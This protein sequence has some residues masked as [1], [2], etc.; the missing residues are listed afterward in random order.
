MADPITGKDVA[1]E[2]LIA[3][4]RKL[5]K[6]LTLIPA[7]FASLEP[8]ELY[9]RFLLIRPDVKGNAAIA[10]GSYG[11]SAS[12][13]F[14]F[15]FGIFL[16]PGLVNL[17]VNAT[18]TATKTNEAL[19]IIH[20]NLPDKLIAT[21][22]R[23]SRNKRVLAKISKPV[24]FMAMLGERKG[25]SFELAFAASFG[26]GSFSE[27]FSLGL[28]GF[29]FAGG[30]ISGSISRDVYNFKDP[31]PGWYQSGSDQN[32][33][34]DF[35]DSLGTRHTHYL[36]R[37]IALWLRYVKK[38]Y[39]KKLPND[40]KW[41]KLKQTFNNL[42][43]F[44]PI[45]FKASTAEVQFKL[46]NILKELDK[47][48]EGFR[49]AKFDKKIAD[50]QAE[51]TKA[52]AANK[53]YNIGDTKKRGTRTTLGDLPDLCKIHLTNMKGQTSIDVSVGNSPVTG[54]MGGGSGV[55]TNVASGNDKLD[56]ASTFT[57]PGP[58]LGAGISLTGSYTRTH[59]RYQ[60]YGYSSRSEKPIVHTQD[61]QIRYTKVNL[62]VGLQASLDFLVGRDIDLEGVRFFGKDADKLS[63]N[64]LSYDKSF[65]NKMSYRAVTAYWNHPTGTPSSVKTLNGSGVSFGF[66]IRIQ[67]LLRFSRD[68]HAGTA[69]TFYDKEIASY[70]NLL[71][72]TSSEFRQFVKGLLSEEDL[73]NDGAYE[74]LKAYGAVLVESS[75][76]FQE[77][78]E[79]SFKNSP[80]DLADLTKSGT[81]WS[82][83]YNNKSFSA[84]TA[85]L[86][87]ES[88]RMRL[89]LSDHMDNSKNIFRL[90]LYLFGSGAGVS[91]DKVEQAGNEG[92]LDFYTHWFLQQDQNI[93]RLHQNYRDSVPPVILLPHT[94]A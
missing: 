82:D 28:L 91:V 36:K 32:L 68:E 26:T 29:T 47:L 10:Y 30:Q 9:E 81:K 41:D 43:K 5:K 61:T 93:G 65:V 46:A 92:I 17:S 94:F 66:S 89:R 50:Y 85:G 20:R 88:I 8:T 80:N 23:E 84:P 72:V 55:G 77:S 44:Y 60:S 54:A 56:A 74:H 53:E 48:D 51:L 87:L 24:T 49:D 64:N 58:T 76:R 7:Q 67:T 1:T 25:G 37:E 62:A 83:F 22:S 39:I 86:Q 71:R 31:S 34:L 52:A 78:E 33:Q 42:P 12:V 21:S 14:G 79:I 38:N 75:F 2:M 18:A 16:C 90:G 69:N 3:T 57:I 73:K 45:W 27:I 70:A 40:S 15:E 6:D 13:T 19:F 35:T 59:Y 4:T 11:H 63:L